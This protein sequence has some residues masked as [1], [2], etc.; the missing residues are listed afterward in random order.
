MTSKPEQQLEPIDSAQVREQL[1]L[2]PLLAGAVA[3]FDARISL[4][5]EKVSAEQLR[6]AIRQEKAARLAARSPRGSGDAP[7]AA[8]RAPQV[9][10]EV[11]QRVPE[12]SGEAD[13]RIGPRIR[14]L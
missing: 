6:K 11:E 8:N 3:I 10:P 9:S 14:S 13:R 1:K 2:S 4:G 12:N 7:P 5:G